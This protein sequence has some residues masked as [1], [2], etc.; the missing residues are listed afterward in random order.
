VLPGKELWAVTISNGM[1]TPVII[2]H[3]ICR[4]SGRIPVAQL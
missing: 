4:R 2:G 1:A 3:A